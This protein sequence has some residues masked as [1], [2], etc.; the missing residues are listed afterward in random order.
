MAGALLI[1]AH[2]LSELRRLC[3]GKGKPRSQ[4]RIHVLKLCGKLILN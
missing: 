4:P 2:S 3:Y 1:R